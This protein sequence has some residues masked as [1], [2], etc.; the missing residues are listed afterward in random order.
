MTE[1]KLDLLEVRV[2]Q[3]QWVTSY[4]AG[5]ETGVGVGLEK[6]REE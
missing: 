2:G 4:R 3:Q 6:R 1:N 5:G